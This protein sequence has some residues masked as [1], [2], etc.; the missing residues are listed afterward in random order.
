[1]RFP[2][3]AVR[4]LGWILVLTLAQSIPLTRSEASV[5]GMTLFGVVFVIGAIV[6]FNRSRIRDRS[7]DRST[8][9]R[10]EIG[11]SGVP[12]GVVAE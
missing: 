6:L 5:V 12:M 7:R 2:G 11:R 3:C 9:V 4:A 10:G 1:M 8:S